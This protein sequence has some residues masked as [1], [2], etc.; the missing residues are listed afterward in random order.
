MCS[1]I[2]F[3]N[4]NG[5]MQMTADQVEQREKE[6]PDDVHEMPVEARDLDRRMVFRRKPPAPGKIEDHR[7]Q[8]EADD[9]MQCVEARHGKVDPKEHARRLRQTRI[10]MWCIPLEARAGKKVMLELG[11]VFDGFD[12]QE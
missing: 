11:V 12:A 5:S 4:T 9:H 6:N 2:A 3:L 7:R 10:V 8:T 1:D